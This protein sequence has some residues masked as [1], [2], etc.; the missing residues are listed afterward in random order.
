MNAKV[1]SSQSSQFGG[2]LRIVVGKPTALVVVVVEVVVVLWVGIV[3]R[4]TVIAPLGLGGTAVAQT[5][6]LAAS[7]R[8]TRNM[9][10]TLTRSLFNYVP[11]PLSFHAHG[12]RALTSP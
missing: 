1:G 11:A 7:M 9:L 6:M 3:G 8:R 12:G 4:V 10:T 5:V 2:V